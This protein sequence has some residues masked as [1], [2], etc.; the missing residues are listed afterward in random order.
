MIEAVNS[1][2]QTSGLVRGNAEQVSNARSFASNPERIQEAPKAPYISPHIHVDVNVNK[3]VIQIRDADTGEV[4]AQ[5]PSETRLIA[6][7]QAQDQ[8]RQERQ[9]EVSESNVSFEISRAANNS[10]VQ[11]QIQASAPAAADLAPAPSPQ[12]TAAFLV[13]AR[14]GTGGDT[15]GNVAVTA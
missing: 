8:A 7:S 1:V 12:Q 15:G 5:I 13:A 4:E 3:A 2:L 10:A 9:T 6:L 14:S 11:A